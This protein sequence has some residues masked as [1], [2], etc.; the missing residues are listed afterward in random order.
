MYLHFGSQPMVILL[1]R[2]GRT[3]TAENHVI[4]EHARRIKGIRTSPYFVTKSRLGFA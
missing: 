4:C 2:F 3:Q 1:N